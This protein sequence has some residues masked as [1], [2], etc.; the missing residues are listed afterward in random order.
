MLK[1]DLHSHTNCSDGVLTPDQLLAEASAAGIDMFSITDHDT[2]AAYRSLTADIP[3]GLTLVPG[4]E[5]SCTWRHLTIHIVGLGIDINSDF[6]HKVEATQGIARNNRFATI[7]QKLEKAGLKIDAERVTAEAGNTPGRPHIAR[8]LL[9]TGQVKSERQAFDKYLGQGKPGDIK[10]CWPNVEQIVQYIVE[11]GGIAVLAHPIKYKLTRTKLIE[12]CTEFKTAGG[13][14]I[15]VISGQQTPQQMTMITAIAR[16]LDLFASVGSDFHSPEQTW[17][18]LGRI[19]ELPPQ[20]K[21]V[22]AQL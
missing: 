6:M 16:Q 4:I 22:W 7:L 10:A 19:P 11:L 13:K 12:L 20:L 5:L 9:E 18:K 8:Y 15:E 2:V 21:P 14:A 1:V 3:S 17:I